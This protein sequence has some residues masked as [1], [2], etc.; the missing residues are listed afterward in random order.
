MTLQ[1]RIQ[2]LEQSDKRNTRELCRLTL[3]LRTQDHGP[4]AAMEHKRSHKA[5]PVKVKGFTLNDLLD[6]KYGK[7]R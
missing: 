2:R 7:G 1:E 4:G 6:R 5:Q 3:L